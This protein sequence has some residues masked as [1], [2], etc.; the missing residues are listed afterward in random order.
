MLPIE[1]LSSNNDIPYALRLFNSL[2]NIGINKSWVV[3]VDFS[4]LFIDALSFTKF[5]TNE[6]KDFFFITIDFISPDLQ[7]LLLFSENILLQLGSFFI[8]TFLNLV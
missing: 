5:F 1:S 3:W 8:L 7:L 4:N 2:I 6:F